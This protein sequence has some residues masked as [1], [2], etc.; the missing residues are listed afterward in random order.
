MAGANRAS[1]ARNIEDSG[2]AKRVWV[3]RLQLTNFRN[4]AHLTLDVDSRP[5]V[6]AGANGSGKT[7]LLEAVSLLAPGQGL[8][9][10]PYAELAR[11]GTSGWAVAARVN[12]PAGTIDV[13]TGLE[14]AAGGRAGRTVRING[15]NGTAASALADV[16]E[17]LWL[18]PSM[19]GLFAGPGSERRRFL[20]RLIASFDP[21]YRTLVARFERAMQQRNRLL[22]DDVRDGVRFEG[23]ERLMADAAV[24]IAAARRA[25][26]AEL[27]GAICRRRDGASSA[28]FPWAE[29]S[30][31]G[32]L[33]TALQR[34]PAIDVE[35]G[36]AA[37][38]AASRERDRAA[39]RALTGPHRSDLVVG[40]G[41]KGM[42]ASACSTG[43]QKALLIGLVL[44]HA[45]LVAGRAQA[46]PILLLD[47]VAAHLDAS[48]RGLLFEEVLALGGQTWLSGSDAAAFSGLAERAQL[49]QVEAGRIA[50]AHWGA[51][52]SASP[53][54]TY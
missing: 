11:T 26:A 19:D 53:A 45:D 47:E 48:R 40:H 28:A 49:L 42:P 9:R 43:E 2:G 39:R 33:E 7:N 52:L 46:A 13:G 31:I 22:V 35:D 24:A 5:V 23:F 34:A 44:A 1:L 30:L 15:A 27:A 16:G 18:T 3:E 20:D 37:E 25:T 21:G 4:Y 32:T 6:V 41:P 50:V 14:N 36:Y 54:I 10:T 51:S 12:V 8:R 38:L 29:L 17:V